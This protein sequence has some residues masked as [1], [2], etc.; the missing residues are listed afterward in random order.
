M[1]SEPTALVA[2]FVLILI[3][4]IRRIAYPRPYP[5][6]PYNRHSANRFLGDLPE[7]L[8]AVKTTKDPA[9]FA[10]QQCRKLQSPVIQLFLRP[11]SRPFI[12]IDDVREVEDL[13]VTRTREFDRA[14][15]T[16]AVFKPFVP[17]SSIIKLTTPEWRAQ[18]RIWTDV[19]SKDFL[20]QVAASRMHKAGMDLVELWRL[21]ADI[22][23][24]HAFF[25]QEDCELATFDAIWAAI[26]GSELNGVRDE[27]RQIRAKASSVKQAQDKDVVASIPAVERG[28]MY[29]AAYYFNLTVEKTLTS[30]APP[31]HHWILRQTPTYK[32]HWAVTQRVISTLIKDARERF[33]NLSDAEMA[34]RA[35]TCAMDLVLRRELS[36]SQKA[37]VLAGVKPP[38]PEEIHDELFMFLIAGHE[39]TATTLAWATKFL[40]N[41]PA[42]QIK[43]RHAL[44]SAFP[45]TTQPSAHEILTTEIPYLDATLEE[46]TRLANIVPRLVRTA[47][48]DTQI[49]GYPV[50]KGAIIMASSYVADEP[51]DIP[52]VQRGEHSQSSKKNVKSYYTGPDMDEFRPER[53]IDQEGRFDMHALPRLA[54]SAGPRACFGKKLALQELRIMLTLVLLNFKFEAIPAHLNSPYGRQKA[55]RAPQQCYVRLT[56]LT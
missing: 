29:N 44:Q 38:M 22:A 14:P 53:W 20:T 9:K 36:A 42:V 27:I 43:L 6:I 13:I 8:E 2:F 56:A 39:T 31:L 49:L 4:Y 34:G 12:F 17:H 48:V 7:L 35:D 15:T 40:A 25:V 45:D 51:F 24:G 30:P 37:N 5:G 46:L 41:N 3:L 10:F 54:F 47:T 21:K 50:P 32:K 19:M 23:D 52:E 11:F 18:R 16:I 55:L 33:S 26:L 1:E 28:E